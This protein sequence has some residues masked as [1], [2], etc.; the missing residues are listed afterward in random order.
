[1]SSSSSVY[2]MFD[3]FED[4]FDR[5]Q[6]D[7][8]SFSLDDKSTPATTTA[9]LYEGN[10][11]SDAERC[12][13]SAKVQ[14]KSESLDQEKTQ[15]GLLDSQAQFKVGNAKQQQQQQECNRIFVVHASRYFARSE[16]QQQASL[17]TIAFAARQEE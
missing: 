3:V 11:A 15:S 16:Q 5:A 10:E 13:H 2:T 9:S 8:Q 17:C 12:R 1:M 4:G 6:F 7:Y 14:V